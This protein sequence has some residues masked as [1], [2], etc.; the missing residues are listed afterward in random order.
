MSPSPPTPLPWSSCSMFM[1]ATD[2]W[3]NGPSN[4]ID[5]TGEQQLN[6]PEP[7][8]IRGFEYEG[9]VGGLDPADNPRNAISKNHI[10]NSSI[11]TMNGEERS[12]YSV[13][14]H[15]NKGE[16]PFE[17]KLIPATS[18]TSPWGTTD[19]NT[20]WQFERCPEETVLS[21]EMSYLSPHQSPS[22]VAS[23]DTNSGVS[24]EADEFETCVDFNKIQP[25]IEVFRVSE[26]NEYS[27]SLTDE[28]EQLSESFYCKAEDLIS[29]QNPTLDGTVAVPP[30]FL[31]VLQE[32]E[33]NTSDGTPLSPSVS[34][35]NVYDTR[36]PIVT[37]FLSDADKNDGDFE[38]EMAE[39]DVA[40]ATAITPATLQSVSNDALDLKTQTQLEHNYTI[41][42]PLLEAGNP[43]Y[44]V[45]TNNTLVKEHSLKPRDTTVILPPVQQPPK[46]TQPSAI[47]RQLFQTK[48]K[49]EMATGNKL[50]LKM[51]TTSAPLVAPVGILNTPDLTNQVLELEAEAEI[52]S[53]EDQFDLITYLSSGTDY[54]VVPLSPVEEKPTV[55]KEEPVQPESTI[56][57]E[58]LSQLLAN[59]AKRKLPMITLDN[60]EE[61]TGPLTPKK[62]RSATS[63]TASSVCGDSVSEVSSSNK[64]RRGRP[65]KQSSLV[66]DRTE[67]QH[68]SEE[69]QRY[70]EQR[71]KNNEAS[72]KSRINR[73]DR[74]LKLEHEANA[75]NQ[76]YQELENEERTLIRD[77]A[78]WRRAVMRLALL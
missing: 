66:S 8:D 58:A 51:P 74:E 4:P 59:P 40:E 26:A 38:Q 56:C 68:L 46:R 23:P 49:S 22:G 9:S 60:L 65:P 78:R 16:Q 13:G 50:K 71:D 25:N 45:T 10:T 20:S 63:S 43:G 36:P 31:K 12:N 32:E 76:Q 35:G 18:P 15:G 24:S 5:T 3:T 39:D 41:K 57:P 14:R 47:K 2:H 17:F 33:S 77:C 75:L 28:I 1:V 64:K 62:F 27:T 53:A 11:T 44:L 48:M 69:D 19:F 6:T 30:F 52:L 55:P 29:I 67:Y 61:L 7:V 54:D 70:R 73:R 37:K 42:L 34:N 21:P 72:R